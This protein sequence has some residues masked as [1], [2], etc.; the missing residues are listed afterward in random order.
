[1]IAIL[2]FAGLYLNDGL[3][4]LGLD[5]NWKILTQNRS[6]QEI[7][8]WLETQNII[9]ALVGGGIGAVIGGILGAMLGPAGIVAGIGIGGIAGAAT[10]SI[11]VEGIEYIW[12]EKEQVYKS[13]LSGGVGAPNPYTQKQQRRIIHIAY[14]IYFY[15]KITTFEQT[16]KGLSGFFSQG[17]NIPDFNATLGVELPAF[18]LSVPGVPGLPDWLQGG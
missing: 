9:G 13:V 17:I 8:D 12:D 10:G 1:M 15:H 16:L 11:I 3:N 6:V 18:N 14:A 2:A 4:K 5:P 7:A